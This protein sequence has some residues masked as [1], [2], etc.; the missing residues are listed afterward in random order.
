MGTIDQVIIEL[1]LFTLTP[2]YGYS[3]LLFMQNFV[4]Y[5]EHEEGSLTTSLKATALI[6]IVWMFIAGARYSVG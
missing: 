4:G 3:L 5:E 2:V 1:A 6:S